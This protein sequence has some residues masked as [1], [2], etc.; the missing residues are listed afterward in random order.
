SPAW[1][2]FL[3]RLLRRLNPTRRRRSAPRV[4]KRK[5]VKWHVKRAHHATWPQPKGLPTYTVTPP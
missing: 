3:R 5:Y 1:L 4:I 2:D